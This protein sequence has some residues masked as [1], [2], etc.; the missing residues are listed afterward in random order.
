MPERTS[1]VSWGSLT[2][3]A[4]APLPMAATM[5]AAPAVDDLQVLV[6]DVRVGGGFA[7]LGVRQAAHGGDGDGLLPR[8]LTP[9]TPES[10]LV[11]REYG[12]PPGLVHPAGFPYEGGRAAAD[13]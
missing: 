5:L 12:T 1:W 7:Q 9:R 13:A 6:R 8:S 2:M 10:A 3:P 11:T 4:A